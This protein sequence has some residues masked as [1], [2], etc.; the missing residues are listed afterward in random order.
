MMNSKTARHGLCVLAVAGALLGATQSQ[1]T[2]VKHGLRVVSFA[3]VETGQGT[4]VET[5]ISR[6]LTNRLL[7]AQQ[8][9]VAIVAADGSVRAEQRRAIG[10]A[11]LARHNGR[12]LYVTTDLNVVAGPDDHLSVEWV[13]TTL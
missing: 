1:A 3:R 13:S 9:R 5:R 4:R 6:S 11:Q 7:S 2:E 8:L 12:D 10:P